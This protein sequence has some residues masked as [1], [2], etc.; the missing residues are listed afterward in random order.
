MNGT[1]AIKWTLVL[2]P[3]WQSSLLLGAA[4]V[5]LL[6]AG[7]GGAGI[8]GQLAVRNGILATE[9][10]IAGAPDLHVY[11]ER[12]RAAIL[13]LVSEHRRG[14]SERWRQTLADAIYEQSVAASVDPLMVA[15]IVAKESS[16]RSRV[17][18]HAGAVG[19]MQLR[20]WVAR[21][22]AQRERIEWRGE[23]TL[24]DPELNVKLGI[25]YYQ[26]L[27][28]RFNGDVHK[29]LTAYNFG[30]TRVSRQLRHGTYSGSDYASRVV[31]LYGKLSSQRARIASAASGDWP[32]GARTS[33]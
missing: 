17:V 25:R 22:V 21:D 23:T 7:A 8:A 19:L 3:R 20:P 9:L 18:S 30:P 29:A 16:F 24:H 28:D 1:D 33:S 13:G 10:A 12:D 14:A 11:D 2:P 32:A 26:E 31:R 4:L 15:S 5:S 6:F 27:M